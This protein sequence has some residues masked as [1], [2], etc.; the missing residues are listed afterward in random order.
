MNLEIRLSPILIWLDVLIIWIVELDSCFYKAKY[1]IE[2][3]IEKYQMKMRR[4]MNTFL[5]IFDLP[6]LLIVFS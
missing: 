5:S 4:N 3:V 2:I 1:K 6:F